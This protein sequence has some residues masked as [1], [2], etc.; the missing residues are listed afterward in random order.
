MIK[1]N[2][3]KYIISL[4][5]IVLPSVVALFIKGSVGNMMKGAWYFSWI[6]PLVFAALHTGLLI[7]TRHIDKVKQGKKI[8][9][10]TFFMIPGISLYV[11]SIF[12]AIMLGF[13]F[14]IA[15]VVGVVMG[16]SFIVMGNYMPKAKR[17]ATFGLKIKWTLA[18]DDNWAATHRLGGKLMVIAGVVSFAISFLPMTAFFIT[19]TA[20]L[21][22]T[23][24]V[25]IVYSYRFYKN[26]I[27]TGAA[28]EED[29]Q[30][31]IK[32]SKKAAASVIAIIA[33]SLVMIILIVF[34][35]GLKFEFGEDAFSVKPTLGGGI[36]LEYAE[37]SADDIK[38]CDEKIPGSRVMGYGSAKLL[39]GRFHNDDFGNYTRYTYTK[40]ES[41]IVITL[42]DE[43]IVIAAETTEETYALYE[44]LLSRIDALD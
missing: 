19:F 26:Q 2:K 25:P 3:L 32:L 27:Q 4:I 34:T 7:L 20:L 44:E 1:E 30:S 31:G 41:V 13:E 33:V 14:N 24:I 12:I 17:N 16:I 10:I 15:M 11:G 38:Y 40:S 22:V 37:L 21:A 35:G 9:N 36:E 23:V 43:I 29:Y 39:Y 42:D 5:V 18:N 8:E 6:M 28:T